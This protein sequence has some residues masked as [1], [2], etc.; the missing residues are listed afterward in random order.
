MWHRSANHLAN[1][2]V[3]PLQLLSTDNMSRRQRFM[4]RKQDII[5]EYQRAP[6]DTGSPEVQS[7][8]R[9]NTIAGNWLLK[10]HAV[11]CGTVS[12]SW[13]RYDPPCVCATH[14]KTQ[15]VLVCCC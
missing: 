11:P 5:E 13:S 9:R 10:Q 1:Q 12:L 8:C 14:C 6:G 3:V 2:T 4:Q 15:A 7:E